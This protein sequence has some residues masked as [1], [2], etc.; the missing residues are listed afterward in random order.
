M[1]LEKTMIKPEYY[2]GKDGKDLFDRYEAGLLK[3]DEVIGFYKG[4]II[5]YVTRYKEK[6]GLEDLEKASTYLERLKKYEEIRRNT[7]PWSLDEIKKI[8]RK[9]VKNAKSEDQ[10]EMQ[11]YAGDN[12]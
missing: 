2:Q 1:E 10:K 5:K 3:E 7:V 8:L 4:N 6:N 11:P 9:N 12:H